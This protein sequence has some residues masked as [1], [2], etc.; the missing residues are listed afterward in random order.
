M[1]ACFLQ[2]VFSSFNAFGRA[3]CTVNGLPAPEA[4]LAVFPSGDRW[5][6]RAALWG[7]LKKPLTEGNYN[8]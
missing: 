3:R 7:A 2:P 1:P 5:L 6:L 4:V 8:D